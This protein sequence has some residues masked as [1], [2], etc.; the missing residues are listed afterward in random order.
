MLVFVT[1]NCHIITFKH[2]A[3]GHSRVTTVDF[4]TFFE[5]IFSV[6]S[7]DEVVKF[8]FAEAGVFYFA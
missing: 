8:F 5:P 1:F 2:F 3:I 7:H 4:I 6:Q